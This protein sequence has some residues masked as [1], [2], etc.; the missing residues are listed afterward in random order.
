M[1]VKDEEQKAMVRSGSSEPR[2]TRKRGRQRVEVSWNFGENRPEFWPT[3]NIS[4]ASPQHPASAIAIEEMRPQAAQ[5]WLFGVAASLA[6][7]FVELA[8]AWNV[9]VAS[10][11]VVAEG[12]IGPAVTENPSDIPPVDKVWLKLVTDSEADREILD[13][14][15]SLALARCPGVYSMSY[16]I[17][18]VAR[19]E[20]H[21]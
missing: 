20:Q 21:N 19:L 14:L 5:Y 2:R 12:R 17:P 10:L 9:E 18:T 13:R 3:L 6:G 15:K 7:T 1:S 8:E 16:S 4:S 11:K